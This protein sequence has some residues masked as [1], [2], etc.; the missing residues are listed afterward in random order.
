LTSTGPQG[1]QF[2]GTVNLAISS[3][4]PS[5][6]NLCSLTPTSVALSA[7]GSAQ[8]TLSVPTILTTPS[9]GWQV[10]VTG[11]ATAGSPPPSHPATFTV[12]V[13]AP[14]AFQFNVKETATQIVLTLTYTSATAP[15]PVGTITIAGPGGNPMISESGGV[16]YD[17][18]S[19]AVAGGT[20]TYSLIHRVT[21]T[22]T[23]P[24]SA[25]VWTAYVSLSGV[26]N[27]NLTIE[28]S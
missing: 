13:V 14:A 8:V 25:Q 27:Y 23:A 5:P 12:T 24:G 9:Q 1:D 7:G 2:S 22:V 18:T 16:V 21:F 4:C 6:P 28:V 17:R 26:S 11:T 20:S 15:P 19:I 3:G 10:V